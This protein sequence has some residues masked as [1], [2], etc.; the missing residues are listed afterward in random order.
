MPSVP[1]P[2]DKQRLSKALANTYNTTADATPWE[3]CQQYQAFL[4][5]TADHPDAGRHRIAHN[6]LSDDGVPPGRVRTWLDGGMPDAMR[7][8]Q[9]AE[10]HGWLDWEPD[11]AGTRALNCLVA[12][13]FA[14][15]SISRPFVPL[16]AVD[17]RT[18][19]CGRT[20][21]TRVLGDP[22]ALSDRETTADG[23]ERATELR[24]RTDASPLGRLLVALGAPRGTKHADRTE[25]S[26]PA[27]LDSAPREL[28]VD[29][30]R[31]YV[32]LRGTP[33]DDR[34]ADRV[35]ISTERPQSFKRELHTLFE[36]LATD[37]VRG[38]PR[39]ATYYLSPAAT[40][41]LYCP[42]SV[43]E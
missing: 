21:L 20:V 30:S 24:P 16:V 39:D 36:S 3:L 42:P 43:C 29:W 33:R 35:Q 19:S 17:D 32:W 10:A 1:D 11:T 12:W 9:V 5:Y 38:S 6:M 4:E 13:I 26:L 7:G 23:R 31:T 15:G 14:G 2:T 28:R 40:R 34:P 8:I 25:L 41:A 18:Q 37:A 22:P 27:Y